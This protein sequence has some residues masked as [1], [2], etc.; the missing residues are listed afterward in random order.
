MSKFLKNYLKQYNSAS[1]KA[2]LA[3]LES[4]QDVEYD[5]RS[6]LMMRAHDGESFTYDEYLTWEKQY[7]REIDVARQKE[8]EGEIELTE[9]EVADLS[10][11]RR[12]F[13]NRLNAYSKNLGIHPFELIYDVEQYF[14]YTENEMFIAYTQ[15]LIPEI[16]YTLLFENLKKYMKATKKGQP[17]KNESEESNDSQPDGTVR[18][19]LISEEDYRFSYDDDH[20]YI[21]KNPAQQVKQYVGIIKDQKH[22]FIRYTYVKDLKDSQPLTAAQ[23]D[24]AKFSLSRNFFDLLAF[25]TFMLEEV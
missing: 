17:E 6:L 14:N 23:C 16:N 7:S 8:L 1:P 18:C 11:D 10:K 25:D 9:D 19:Q 5:L 13:M 21:L 15:D 20:Y 4:E 22:G 24:D 2:L 12:K 3:L